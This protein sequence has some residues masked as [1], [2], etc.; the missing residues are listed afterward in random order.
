VLPRDCLPVVTGFRHALFSLFACASGN[1]AGLD[2]ITDTLLFLSLV[3]AAQ[4]Q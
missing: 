3:A 2:D 4:R 1:D